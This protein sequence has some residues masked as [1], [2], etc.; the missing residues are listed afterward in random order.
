MLPSLPTPLLFSFS[1]KQRGGKEGKGVHT[2]AH[3]HTN[4]HT[5]QLRY[6]S[7]ILISNLFR[8]FFPPYFFPFALQKFYYAKKKNRKEDLE[9]FY[10]ILRFRNI[11]P[12][13]R[14]ETFINKKD[15]IRYGNSGFLVDSSRRE[16]RG[17]YFFSA[18]YNFIRQKSCALSSPPI[19][20]HGGAEI[21][22]IVNDATEAGR[23]YRSTV[24]IHPSSIYLKSFVSRR[25]ARDGC[26]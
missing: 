2:H 10:G 14:G 25:F 26:G 19:S 12:W 16:L 5:Y 18:R 9:K 17:S 1:L 15:R 7:F 8:K 11:I 4:T 24:P 23:T 13:G 21:S 20:V 22:S 3:A 6:A